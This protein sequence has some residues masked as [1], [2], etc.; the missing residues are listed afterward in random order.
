MEPNLYQPPNADVANIEKVNK[1]SG[2]RD[3]VLFWEQKRILY[4]LIIGILGSVFLFL[5]I[6]PDMSLRVLVL[7]LIA[8][9]IYGL[10]ANICYSSDAYFNVAYAAY[11][12][13]EVGAWKSLFYLGLGFSVLLIV[14]IGGAIAFG[15]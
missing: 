5:S 6:L 14:V 7:T 9:A 3:I 10:G 1:A 11:K 2:L 15:V 8:A 12:G 4:N 13:D